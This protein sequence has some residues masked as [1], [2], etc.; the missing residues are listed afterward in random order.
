MIQLD[1]SPFEY[2]S[3]PFRNASE[4]Q[5]C[6]QGAD[7]NISIHGIDHSVAEWRIRSTSFPDINSHLEGFGIWLPMSA[8]MTPR[9]DAD[10]RLSTT[11]ADSFGYLI[12]WTIFQQANFRGFSKREDRNERQCYLQH[13]V[14]VRSKSKFL[15]SVSWA[16]VNWQRLIHDCK[17]NSVPSCRRSS[18]KHLNRCLVHKRINT[19]IKR[20]SSKGISALPKYAVSLGERWAVENST[21][22][23]DD[24]MMVTG[25]IFAAKWTT[26]ILLPYFRSFF[27]IRL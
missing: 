26:A 13:R 16:V 5:D 6:T 1:L 4:I 15:K 25:F 10:P 8:K 14:L 3:Q 22:K 21:R 17:S 12:A 2:I 18:C 20:N 23:T 27:V 19:F 7:G 11:T 24:S 9:Q